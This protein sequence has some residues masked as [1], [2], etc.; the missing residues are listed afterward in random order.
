MGVGG[1]LKTLNKRAKIEKK[2]KTIILQIL[3][4]QQVNQKEC[5]K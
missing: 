4:L 1:L 3:F 5:M 2:K